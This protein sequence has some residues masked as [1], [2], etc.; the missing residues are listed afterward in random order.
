MKVINSAQCEKE[1]LEIVFKI[2]KEHYEMLRAACG[3]GIGDQ[4][5]FVAKVIEEYLA[6]RTTVEIG[7][8]TQELPGALMVLDHEPVACTV[9]LLSAQRLHRIA[10]ILDESAARIGKAALMNR[11]EATA[12]LSWQE[13]RIKIDAQEP[14]G[15]RKARGLAMA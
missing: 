7:E 14:I 2:P 15:R 10:G 6:T 8:D 3:T 11:L 4:G 12:L 13:K 5:P 9:S 1:G